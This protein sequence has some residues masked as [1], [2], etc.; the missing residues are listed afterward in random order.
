MAY[1]YFCINYF[2]KFVRI[3]IF[4]F[5]LSAIDIIIRKQIRAFAQQLKSLLK[6][7]LFNIHK[8]YILITIYL[9]LIFPFF[10]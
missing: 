3:D 7:K 8:I 9:Y 1:R 10:I 6:T 5:G 4:R 2:D